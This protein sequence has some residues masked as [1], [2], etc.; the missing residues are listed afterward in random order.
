MNLLSIGNS[1]SQD[2]QAYLWR[3]ANADGRSVKTVNLMIGGCSLERHY[4]NMVSGEA[5]YSFELNGCGSGLQV[6]LEQGLRSDSWDVVTLQQV[7][8]KAPRFETYQPYLSEL[9][10]YVRSLCPGAKLY[11]H[12]T[13]AYEANSA[14]LTEELGYSTPT[15]MLLDVEH[16]YG[17]AVQAISADGMIYSGRAMA[18]ALELGVGAVHRDTFHASLGLGRYLLGL[19]WYQTLTGHPVQS[20]PCPNLDAPITQKEIALAKEAVRISGLS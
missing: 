9:A 15:Q 16:A 13:W 6:S 20:I 18:K 11:L 19:V 3:I 8:H 1:F 10:A 2:A 7:S 4:N 17:Q 5:A 14:R 12:Q